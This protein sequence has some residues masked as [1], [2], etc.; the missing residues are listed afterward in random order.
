MSPKK[1]Q[2][3]AFAARL[4]RWVDAWYSQNST[5]VAETDPKVIEYFASYYKITVEQAKEMDQLLMPLRECDAAN[6]FIK[7][8]QF[9]KNIKAI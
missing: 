8:F 9:L 2:V 5:L 4:Q 7:P 6:K 1:T 3:L